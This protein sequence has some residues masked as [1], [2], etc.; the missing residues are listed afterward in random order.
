MSM[1]EMMRN[2]ANQKR[3]QRAQAA[4]TDEEIHD[5]L[6]TISERLTALE[7]KGQSPPIELREEMRAFSEMVNEQTKI[8][9]QLLAAAKQAQQQAQAHNQELYKQA[10]Q[11]QQGVQAVRKAEKALKARVMRLDKVAYNLPQDVERTYKTVLERVQA[12]TDGL[13]KKGVATILAGSVATVAMTIMAG[14]VMIH[15]TDTRIDLVDEMDQRNRVIGENVRHQAA[16]WDE[17]E[18]EMWDELMGRE[19]TAAE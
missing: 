4:K 17:T 7:N 12:I 11:T 3:E 5:H 13:L 18:Q 8:A 1:N 14:V 19:E 6:R 10:E 9:E 16:Q 2:S 15:Q